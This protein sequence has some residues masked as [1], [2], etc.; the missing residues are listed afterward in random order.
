MLGSDI[1]ATRRYEQ[2][3][4][5]DAAEETRRGILDAVYEE[6]RT[7][8]SRPVSLDRV[9]KAAG[10]SRSTI[11]LV[12]GSRAGL[13][14]ALTTE[15]WWERS[16]FEKVVEA[17]AHPD[18]REH[19]RAGIDAGVRVHAAH[20]A[21]FRALFSMG[22]L[23]ADAIGDA[24]AAV[25]QNRAGGMTHLAERLAEQ[26]ALRPDLSVEDAAHILWLLTGFDA[27]DQ[28]FTGRGL[29]VDEVARLLVDVAERSVCR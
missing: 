5:A 28:L 17:V 9:A 23:D 29:A 13:F 2:R 15:L 26:D 10:V 4:R 27:F 24:I 20:R 11:Y 18:A 16:G 8:P 25:E 19:L 1:V 21:V 14:T 3:L 12:F 7:A 22:Q 6:L